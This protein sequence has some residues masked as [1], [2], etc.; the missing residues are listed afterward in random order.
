MISIKNRKM[1]IPNE[2]RYI[3]TNAD[4]NSEVRTFRVDRYTQTEIDLSAFTAKADILHIGSG[5][6]DR[7]DLEM[8]VQPKYILLHLYI[9]SGMV[10]VPGTRLIELKLFNDDGVV[11]WS[12]YRGAFYVEDSLSSP[13][14]TQETL[15]ELEQLEARIN[16]AIDAAYT[17]AIEAANNWL[18]QNVHPD[19]GYVI[20]ESLTISGAA[21]DARAVG[22]AIRENYNATWNGIVEEQGIRSNADKVLQ[23]QISQLIAPTGAAPNQ[24]EIL[25]ARI[26]ANSITYTTLGKAIREQINGIYE[27]M[28]FLDT[29]TGKT[30]TVNGGINGTMPFSLTGKLEPMQSG[31]GTPSADNIR[32]FIKYDSLKASQTKNG[33]ES[34]TTISTPVG[35]FIGGVVNCLNG[36]WTYPYSLISSYSQMSFDVSGYRW[37]SDRDE[38]VP[39][40]QPSEGAEVV[41]ESEGWQGAGTVPLLADTMGAGD[42]IY[43]LAAESSESGV[44]TPFTLTIM[45]NVMSVKKKIA[46]LISDVAA[47][48]S[49]VEEIK[50]R[51]DP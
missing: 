37:W 48:K 19:T 17:K 13:D 25:D 14:Y 35:G 41:Y 7:A 30:V 38:Y 23:N 50:Q 29:F 43:S 1:L 26:G 15:T 6:I 47:L 39:G 20:D 21:A 11:K 51:L 31:S 18:D 22:V 34:T 24:A 49:D 36:K 16:R 45:A 33:T 27:N 12:S 46:E 32:P 44:T 2:E 9:T 5:N 42:N 10:A 3:G 4:N 40:G 28:T 8:E